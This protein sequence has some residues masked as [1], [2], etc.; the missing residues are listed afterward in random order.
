MSLALFNDYYRNKIYKLIDTGLEL[1]QISTWL[2]VFSR[3]LISI[4]IP[5]FL[6]QMDYS[7]ASVMLY[8]MIYNIFDFLV[9][10]IQNFHLTILD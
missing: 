2:H 8:Y 1:F 5:I 6:L 3:S 4:F 7:I 9:I 10:E